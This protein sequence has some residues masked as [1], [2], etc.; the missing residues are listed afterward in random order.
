MDLQSIFYL[1]AVI[2]MLILIAM[3]VSVIA[4]LWIIQKK[5]SDLK[6]SAVDKV[7]SFVS[8]SR[9]GMLSSAGISIAGFVIHKLM[10]RFR[11]KRNS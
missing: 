3:A 6:T 2:F 4:V 7:Q 10:S 8:D 9:K 5:V 11:D 1:V